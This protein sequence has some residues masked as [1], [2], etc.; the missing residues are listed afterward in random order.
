MHFP[1][2]SESSITPRK[3]HFAMAAAALSSSAPIRLCDMQRNDFLKEKYHAPINDSFDKGSEE[4]FY[5]LSLNEVQAPTF[6]YPLPF[7]QPINLS[8]FQPSQMGC[9]PTFP[10]NGVTYNGRM[11]PTFR[12]YTGPA[13]F[14]TPT[15]SFTAA[16]S[17]ASSSSTSL[18]Y[19]WTPSPVPL[20]KEVQKAN[21]KSKSRGKRVTRNVTQSAKGELLIGKPKGQRGPNKRPPG[22]AFSNLLVGSFCLIPDNSRT[23]S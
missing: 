10:A 2:L 13:Y 7:Q 11:A 1:L 23:F 15:T 17:L 9:A 4:S 19:P 21:T 18:Q 8:Y 22:A 16:P 5:P 6:P 12:P 20:R 14:Q 3:E